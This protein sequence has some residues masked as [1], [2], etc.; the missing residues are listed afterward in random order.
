MY[1]KDL[2]SIV[3][4]YGFFI[5]LYADDTQLYFA[6]DVHCSNPDLTS[7]NSC[8]MEIKQWMARNF[9]KLNDDK[10][11]FVDI[12]PYQSPITSLRLG[13]YPRVIFAATKQTRS[14]L[15]PQH[16]QG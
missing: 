13:E 12:G 1:T 2:E 16:T 8:F 14:D 10:T 9:L 4:K 6:F 5:H 11:E 7:V 15:H 3:T